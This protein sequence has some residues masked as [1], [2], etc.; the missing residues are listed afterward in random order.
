MSAFDVSYRSLEPDHQR[1]FRRLGMS[2]CASISPAAAA[3]LG[4][5]TLAEAQ[6]A[7]A[8]LLDHHLLARAPGGQFRFHDLIREYAALR[9]TRRTPSRSGGGRS[10]GCSTTI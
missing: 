1:F 9:A 6:Q 5:V 2:P 3:A 10:A 7:L 8:A 4:G